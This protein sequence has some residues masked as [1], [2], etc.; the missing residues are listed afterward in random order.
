[1]NKWGYVSDII[2]KNMISSVTQRVL[3]HHFV[4]LY[5]VSRVVP[6]ANEKR[7]GNLLYANFA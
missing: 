6:N 4:P 3:S 1:M 2:N 5:S 7:R